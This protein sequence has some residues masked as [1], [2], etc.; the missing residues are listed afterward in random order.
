MTSLRATAQG[1]SYDFPPA[2]VVSIGCSPDSDVGVPS[3]GVVPRH[4]RL[5]PDGDAWHLTG[6]HRVIVPRAST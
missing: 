6:E 4:A 1:L 3:P 2:A 5:V